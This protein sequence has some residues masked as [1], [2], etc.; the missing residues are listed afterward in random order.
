MK[1][2]VIIGGGFAGA[3]CA[4]KLENDFFVTLIDAKNYFEFTLGVL[5]T[6]IEPEHFE[7]IH[8]C[9]A[10][11]LHKAT[12]IHGKA[13]RVTATHVRACGRDIHYDYLVIATGHAT[14]S[15]SSK[16]MLL[17]LRV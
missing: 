4:R 5:R 13:T 17:T 11:Y 1:H 12:I 9:H 6:L 15:R 16:Q 14:T 3:Y 2:V 7:K 10:S 8:M